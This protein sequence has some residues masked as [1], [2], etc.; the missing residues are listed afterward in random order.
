LSNREELMQQV[1]AWLQ[2]L[3]GDDGPS[4]PDLEYDN[5][6]LELSK[7]AAGRPE[8]QFDRGAPPDWRGV[9][10]MV[11]DLFERTHDLRI[12]IL[13]LRAAVS[14]EGVAALGP[15]LN[16]VVSL[17]TEHWDD[18]HPK[19]DPDDNDPYG[20]ANALG[21]LPSMDGLLGDLTNSRIVAIKGVGELR[22]R[23]AEVALGTLTPRSGE[24]TYTRDQIE[25]MLA[26]ADQAGE[27]VRPAIL[28]AQAQI[29]RLTTAMDERFGAGSAVEMKPLVDLVNRLL[30]LTREPVAEDAAD[31]A[32]EGAAGEGGAP[33]GGRRGGLS[34]GVGS[35][36]EAVRAIDM[37]CEYLER[38]EPTNPAPLFLRR[39][40]S[41][42]ERNFLELLKELAPN[43]LDDVARTVGIDPSTVGEPPS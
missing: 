10:S 18:V 31:G 23:D 19:P 5:A 33:G 7:A 1:S 12:A 14:L 41:L 11:E 8:T 21:S 2:P 40:R 39:A 32:E 38:A 16:L 43:A 26:A 28:D 34:G 36:V 27:G 15:G 29:K 25:K 4:G 42:L 37:V 6:F 9:R 13:W 22:V 30:S 24:A 20:R 3:S 17:L 35:R